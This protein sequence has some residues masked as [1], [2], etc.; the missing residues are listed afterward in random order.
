LFETRDKA[1]E[2]YVNETYEAV[3]SLFSSKDELIKYINSLDTPETAELF[4]KICGFY[5]ISKKYQPLSYVKLIMILSA[6]ERTVSKD[7]KYQEFSFWIDKQIPKIKAELQ[8]CEIINEK[9]YL[10]ILRKLREDYFKIYGSS[11][12]VIEFFQN[13]VSKENKIKLIKSFRANRTKII[14]NFS[15]NLF[16]LTPSV[17]PKTIEEA[18]EKFHERIDTRMMPYCYDWQQCFVGYGNCSPEMFCPLAHNDILLGKIL[19]KVIDD[20][21]QMRND[22]VHTARITALNEKDSIGT[23][24][25]IGAERKPVSVELTAEDLETIFES[26]LKHYFDSFV[27]EESGAERAE[28]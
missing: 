10:Q 4:I 26:G 17:V 16:G 12:N 24:I 15:A 21:Y 20:I 6:I 5:L 3:S 7:K 18:G 22:F 11:R 25:V 13:H 1:L 28:R 14:A 23:L 27:C 8:K 9:T 19:K 2:D